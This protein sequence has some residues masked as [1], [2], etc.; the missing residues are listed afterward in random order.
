MSDTYTQKHG[1]VDIGT[2]GDGRVRISIGTF[3][4]DAIKTDT[5]AL[6][7]PRKAREIAHDIFYFA[8]QAEKQKEDK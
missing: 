3:G 7:T 1:F 5:T 8:D 4:L 6:V 2:T